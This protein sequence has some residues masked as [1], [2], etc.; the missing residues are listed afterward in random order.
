MSDK[1]TK[2]H[3]DPLGDEDEDC[4]KFPERSNWWRIQE[5]LVWGKSEL[6]IGKLIFASSVF[7]MNI[8]DPDIASGLDK[9]LDV[10]D[11]GSNIGGAIEIKY[12]GTGIAEGAGTVTVASGGNTAENF[13]F[14]QLL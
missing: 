11:A 6:C 3:S 5:V 14:R 4:C 9:G 10:A 1:S 12:G 2:S 8:S 13:R 7:S